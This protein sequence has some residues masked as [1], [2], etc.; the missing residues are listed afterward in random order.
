[1][2]VTVII[3]T[4]DEEDWIAATVTSAFAA[5]A[6]EVIV[7]DGGSVDRTPRYATGA[8]ARVLLAEQMRARQL[9]LG[10]HAA[11][12]ETLIFL[13]ADT[14]LPPNAAQAVES[15]LESGAD[16]GGFRIDFAEEAIK[17]RLAAAMINLRTRLTRCPWGDQAQFIRRQTFFGA[18]CFLEIPLMEDYELA[19]RMKRRGRSVLLP[20]A[21]TTS[22]RRFLR[23]GVIRTAAHNWRTIM[24]YRGGEDIDALA[25]SYRK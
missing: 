6:A 24:R 7:A 19:Q 16:F 4:F 12:H 2:P 5:G 9:N 13:H 20:M 21:V 15:A 10:A 25:R 8:G 23:K 17:L 11:S 1:M 14:H 22:G 3:P 18:G